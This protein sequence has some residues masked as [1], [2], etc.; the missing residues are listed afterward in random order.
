MMPLDLNRPRPQ[1][2]ALPAGGAPDYIAAPRT[3]EATGIRRKVLEDL[4]L[5]ILHLTGELSLRELA[6]RMRV[7][8]RI[9]D[10][11]FGRL[12]KENLCHVT[13]MAAGIHRIVTT[14]EGKER[15]IELLAVTQYAGPVPVSLPAYVDRVKAQTVRN[16][17]I[18]AA[19]VRRAFARLVLPDETI[20][21]LGTALA[22]GRAIFLYGPPGTGKT[23]I[24][25]S[26]LRLFE[27][28]T[29]WVPYAVEADGQIIEVFDPGIHRAL[30]QPDDHDHDAR[31]VRCERPRVMVGGELTID[32]LDLQYNPASR[33]YAAPVQMKASNGLLIVDDFG[34][35]RVRPDELLNRWV[36]PL[37][38]SIDFLTL[39]GGRKIE[40]PFDM[41]VVFATNLDPSDLV[42]EAFLRRI[43]TKIRLNSIT[44]DDFHEI[45]RR[46]CSDLDLEY[47][48][49]PI[50]AL[51]D[52]IT[53]ELQ[54]ELRACFPGDLIQQV[55]WTAR[56]RREVPRLDATS[57]D[58]ACRTYFVSR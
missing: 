41:L 54:L 38:R 9:V 10:E 11:I 42:D 44:R 57:L 19:M 8:L 53:H 2:N 55:C 3:I 28:E 32:M 18:D 7:P 5:K 56:Y 29:I 20:T 46:V 15:A 37:D 31:W 26:M 12:R 51:I 6:E 43:Q 4:A 50:D 33:F 17:N 34:R 58:L 23:T 45:S 49:A 27:V 25:D 48:H 24:A 52:T 30:P 1:R 16:L 35:Q 13:G 47:Q 14:S 22:S 36:V 40:I 21:Q 39:A